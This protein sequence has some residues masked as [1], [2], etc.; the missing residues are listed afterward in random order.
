MGPPLQKINYLHDRILALGRLRWELGATN[1]DE[2]GQARGPALM[3]S[4]RLRSGSLFGLD[5]GRGAYGLNG[6][7]RRNVFLGF[8]IRRQIPRKAPEDLYCM[9]HTTVYV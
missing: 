2:K 3:V 4:G 5:R 1:L 8:A 9:A 6:Q 7:A